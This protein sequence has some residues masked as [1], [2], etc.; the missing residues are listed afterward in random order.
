MATS[1]PGVGAAGGP[2]SSHA[3]KVA[4]DPGEI[5]IGQGTL[6]VMDGISTWS[7]P[8]AVVGVPGLLVV[9]WVTLQTFGALAWIPAV[10]R[11]RGDED[12]RRKRGAH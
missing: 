1:S 8:A 4:P 3:P 10:R 11:L 2:P 9:L 7:V 6:S 12:A 5:T